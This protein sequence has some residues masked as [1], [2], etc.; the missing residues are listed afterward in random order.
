MHDQTMSEEPTNIPADRWPVFDY[1]VTTLGL[2]GIGAAILFLAIGWA[3]IAGLIAVASGCVVLLPPSFSGLP[4]EPNVLDYRDGSVEG[5]RAFSFGCS[6]AF[7]FLLVCGIVKGWSL[8]P[9]A[10][11]VFSRSELVGAAFIVPWMIRVVARAH[12]ILRT[13]PPEA[14]A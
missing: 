6:M 4:S 3:Q 11:V 14:E 2:S 5:E 7:V 13:A 10:N 1:V 8:A 9:D 12:R